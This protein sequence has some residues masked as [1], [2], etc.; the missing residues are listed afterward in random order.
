MAE[1]SPHPRWPYGRGAWNDNNGGPL[2]FGGA[3]RIGY[4]PEIIWNNLTR[5]AKSRIAEW[6]HLAR[7]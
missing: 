7:S 1:G 4:D 6:V 3:V 5:I 2:F